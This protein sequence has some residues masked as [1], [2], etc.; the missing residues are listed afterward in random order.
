MKQVQSWF[1]YHY[2]PPGKTLPTHGQRLAKLNLMLSGITAEEVWE[3]LSDSRKESL[4]DKAKLEL[5]KQTG[6]KYDFTVMSLYKNGEEIAIP[7]ESFE[8]MVDQALLLAHQAANLGKPEIL[9]WNNEQILIPVTDFEFPK[10]ATAAVAFQHLQSYGIM[11]DYDAGSR[12]MRTLPVD[13][14][15]PELRFYSTCAKREGK[16]LFLWVYEHFQNSMQ[17]LTKH[18]GV[19]LSSKNKVSMSTNVPRS[20]A[21]MIIIVAEQNGV[22]TSQQIATILEKWTKHLLK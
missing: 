1:M 11:K 2:A 18:K 16:P 3:E 7:L 21:N 19:K 22:S 13:I 12:P 17:K 9:G 20:V 6:H 4:T 14:S 8:A 15:G 10:T 5:S